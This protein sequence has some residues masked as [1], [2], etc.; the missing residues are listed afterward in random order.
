VNAAGYWERFVALVLAVSLI[1][2]QRAIPN[3]APQPPPPPFAG[4]EA[5]EERVVAGIKVRWCPPGTFV[6]GSPP[7]EPERRPD[8][9]QVEVSL[10][11]GFRA[12]R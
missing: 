4:S 2:C 7:D 12:P 9:A 3:E 1:G 11:R 8:E 5:G 6:M 10:T